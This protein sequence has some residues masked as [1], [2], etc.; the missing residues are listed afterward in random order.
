MLKSITLTYTVRNQQQQNHVLQKKN[1]GG[2]V[3]GFPRLLKTTVPSHTVNMIDDSNTAH[4]I[5][6]I[7]YDT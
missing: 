5:K 1:W 2:C 4:H 3:I 7:L 6:N